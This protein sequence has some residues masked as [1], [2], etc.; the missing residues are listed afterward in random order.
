M[1]ADVFRRLKTALKETA[2]PFGTHMRMPD[3][4]LPG[5]DH[6]MLEHISAPERL[7]PL[8]IAQHIGAKPNA[9]MLHF[10]LYASNVKLFKEFVRRSFNMNLDS[11]GPGYTLNVPG[12]ELSFPPYTNPGMP[13]MRVF[14]TS[15][16]RACDPGSELGGGSSRQYADIFLYCGSGKFE[17]IARQVSKEFRAYA[18]EHPDADM[19][20]GTQRASFVRY[21]AIEEADGTLPE[22]VNMGWVVGWLNIFK[23]LEYG[24]TVPE[25]LTRDLKLFHFKSILPFPDTYEE[26]RGYD[27]DDAD[28]QQKGPKNCVVAFE[29][30]INKE[31]TKLR[32]EGWNIR[33]LNLAVK[34]NCKVP[35][36]VDSADASFDYNQFIV[37]VQCDRNE[38]SQGNWE[39]LDK[40][41]NAIPL[42]EEHKPV[43]NSGDIISPDDLT[44]YPALRILLVVGSGFDYA[45]MIPNFQTQSALVDPL[46]RLC[47]D[48]EN[49]Y[50][51][52]WEDIKDN[53]GKNTGEKK[54][55]EYNA[56]VIT[57]GYLPSVSDPYR[58]CSRVVHGVVVTKATKDDPPTDSLLKNLCFHSRVVRGHYFPDPSNYPSKLLSHFKD[59][60]P[61]SKEVIESREQF[62]EDLR[63][64]SQD[65][66]VHELES[67]INGAVIN[68][69]T[70]LSGDLK[71]IVMGR[72]YADNAY[73]GIGQGFFCPFYFWEDTTRIPRHLK[74]A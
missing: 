47:T 42:N 49:K 73:V 31:L 21:P 16:F 55:V 26:S 66:R 22:W 41:G 64:T 12:I 63:H 71:S 54:W 58:T 40:D 74:E 1:D 37:Q 19:S 35:G 72:M 30:Y 7:R 29:A 28:K 25:S 27:Q 68:G 15:F 70:T 62:L 46:N 50:R 33:H 59:L 51:G 14:T 45:N 61:N 65:E 3:S 39:P 56:G 38:D 8:R 4:Y 2:D 20:T 17:N 36:E 69:L 9:K 60:G 18:K 57:F 13:S 32:D 53:T 67:C 24:K 34:P 5:N 44:V 48:P 6:S 11:C 10:P 43:D 52:A 23:K